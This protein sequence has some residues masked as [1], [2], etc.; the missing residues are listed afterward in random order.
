MQPEAPACQMLADD[1]HA[2]V[3][4]VLAAVLLGERVAIVPSGIR[5]PARLAQERLPFGV[6]EA[7]AIPIRA[8]VFAAVVEE[9]DVVIGSFERC[10]LALDEVVQHVQV[11]GQ[12]GR[13][14]EV[15]SGN[16]S[17]RPDDFPGNPQAERVTLSPMRRVFLTIAL[18]CLVGLLGA[19]KCEPPPPPPVDCAATGSVAHTNLRYTHDT[20]VTANL[21]SLDLYVPVRPDA[22]GAT[23]LV[24]YVH[25][26][27]F[28]T[29]DKANKISDKVRL[30]TGAGWAFASLNYRLVDN[31]GAGPTNGEYPAA[32]QDI[33][34]ALAYLADHA[35]GYSLDPHRIMLLGHSAGAFLVSLVSTDGSFVEAAGLDLGDIVCTTPLDTTYDIPAQ[36]ASGGT[37][38]AMFRNAF[39]DDPAVWQHASP[40]NNV[41]AGKSIPAFHIVTRGAP[42]RVAQSQAFAATLRN[43]GFDATAQVVR[44]LTH[45]EVNAAVGQAGETV[46]TPPLM[47]FFHECA[48]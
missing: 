33:G 36:I 39:G 35:G 37:E 15:H 45:D 21:Q 18:V 22:C 44:G 11:R 41:A 9:P 31:P 3:R 12:I 46:V 29:G 14:L 38:E 5:T 26:G 13:D 10:D 8:G 25:G 17:T 4:P 32:E 27:A 48:A 6:R 19:A 2:E 40:P 28:I 47:D 34:N 16:P 7:A 23:P 42:P 1:G 20:G 43:A 30:F 24:A